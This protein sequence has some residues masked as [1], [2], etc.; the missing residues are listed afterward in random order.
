[1]EIRIGMRFTLPP[2]MEGQGWVNR[3]YEAAMD[4]AVDLAVDHGLELREAVTMELSGG[5]EGG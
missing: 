5:G 2:A 1:M 3:I 4:A